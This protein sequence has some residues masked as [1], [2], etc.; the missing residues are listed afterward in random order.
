MQSLA[1]MNDPQMIE[2]ARVL[3][4][5]L[6][7]ANPQDVNLRLSE[8]FRRWT[9]RK[10]NEKE[11]SVIAKFYTTELARFKA[12]QPAAMEIIE[13]NGEY[14]ID[15]NLPPAEVAALT[16]VQRMML[17]LPETIVKF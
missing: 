7:R 3:A 1:L 5:N 9:G 17:N 10:I 2:C 12:D 6:I 11:L 8:S 16:M 4:E 14:A 15:H 13:K